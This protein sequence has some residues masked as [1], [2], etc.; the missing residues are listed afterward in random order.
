M[1]VRPLTIHPLLHIVEHLRP[2]DLSAIIATSDD[3]TPIEWANEVTDAHG[4][5]FIALADDGEP[6][7]AFG[8]ISTLVRHVM[9]TWFVA[10]P[11]ISDIGL[12][13]HR[14]AIRSHKAMAG[15]GVRRFETQNP[16]EFAR[17]GCVQRRWLDRLGYH[18][19][20]V[21]RGRGAQGQDMISFARLEVA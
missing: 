9:S 5:Q 14:F 18:P 1:L 10:T 3:G 15:D 21:H 19:E 12:S 7:A 16:F 6:V 2:D 17:P 8:F 11:R 4:Q 20:G 13:L